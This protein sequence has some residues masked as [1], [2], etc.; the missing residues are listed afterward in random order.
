M[1]DCPIFLKRFK[2]PVE[3]KRGITI[4]EMMIVVAF[5]AILGVILLIALKPATQLAKSRDA[6]RKADLQKLKNVL[7][8]YYNDKNSYP[9]T[10][11]CGSSFG[12]P[13]APYLDKIPCDPLTK[14]SYAYSGDSTSYRIYVNLEFK[15]D[16]VIAEVGCQ[17]GCGPGCAYNYGIS[18]SNVG[19]E[20]CIECAGVWWACQRGG[21]QCNN[22]G[23]KPVCYL[24]GQ[25]YCN[26][27]LCGG[28]DCTKS[29]NFCTN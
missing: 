22:Y 27:S 26:D 29:A 25:A 24:G 6:S 2:S 14:T 11:T 18:S 12:S 4:V 23:P 9:E 17:D 28:V 3:G 7:E 16:P 10:L 5:L 20:P 8:D 19:L 15:D 13:L 1:D 21:E